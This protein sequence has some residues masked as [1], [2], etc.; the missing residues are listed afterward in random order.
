M[1]LP[2]LCVVGIV[3]SSVLDRMILSSKWTYVLVQTLLGRRCM[4]FSVVALLFISERRRL[5]AMSNNPVN[6]ISTAAKR[7]VVESRIKQYFC[8]PIIN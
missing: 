4:S 3:H 1:D 8:V 7:V 6:D 5:T 2:A